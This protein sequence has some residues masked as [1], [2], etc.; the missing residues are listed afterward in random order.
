MFNFF[1]TWVFKIHCF[2][3][4]VSL[5]FAVR[6]SL[7]SG[8]LQFDTVSFTHRS[9]LGVFVFGSV[10]GAYVF[11]NTSNFCFLSLQFPLNYLYLKIG[12]PTKMLLILECLFYILKCFCVSVLTNWYLQNF[13]LKCQ[14]HVQIR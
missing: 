3:S 5:H 2:L 6:F 1:I 10:T 8:S 11:Y 13:V 7:I 4:F 9:T 14:Y 12:W